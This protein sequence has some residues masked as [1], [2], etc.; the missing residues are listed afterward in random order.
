MH[1]DLRISEHDWMKLR[2]HFE[3]SFRS[4]SSARPGPWRSLENAERRRNGSSSSLRCCFRSRGPERHNKWCSR[5]RCFV[6]SACLLGNAQAS[7][8]WNCHVP[9]APRH[10]SQRR[11]F[12]LRR[13]ARPV[14]GRKPNGTRTAH[15]ICK[16][17]GRKGLPVRPVLRDPPSQPSAETARGGRESSVLLVACWSAATAATAARRHF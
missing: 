4:R 11:L 15:A 14:V 16:R 9:Y 10:V 13:P 17:R 6:H 8:G 1:P 7:P 2:K 5:F 12:A 3:L